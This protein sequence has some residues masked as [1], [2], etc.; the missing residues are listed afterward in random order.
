MN[1][2]YMARKQHGYVF[3]LDSLSRDKLQYLGYCVFL[4]IENDLCLMNSKPNFMVDNH[5]RELR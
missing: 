1:Y 3:F 4:I 5:Q 2:G